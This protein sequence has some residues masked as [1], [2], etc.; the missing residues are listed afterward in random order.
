L[1]L[2]YWDDSQ[3]DNNTSLH[4]GQGLIL[5]IDAHPQAVLFPTGEPAWGRFQAYDSTFGKQRTDGFQLHY[6]SMPW[7]EKSRPAVSVFDD[8]KQYWNPQTPTAGVMNPDTNTRII[9]KSVNNNVGVMTIEVRPT[10]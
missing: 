9:V 5:P 1:L 6:D 8:N 2:N 4:P 10:K 3:S 7:R